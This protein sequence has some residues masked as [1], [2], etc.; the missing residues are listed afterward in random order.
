MKPERIYEMRS[1]KMKYPG[2]CYFNNLQS[3]GLVFAT[4]LPLINQRERGSPLA[5]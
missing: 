4:L 3:L 1:I 2:S 5:R